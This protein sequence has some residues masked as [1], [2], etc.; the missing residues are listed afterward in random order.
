MTGSSEGRS[1]LEPVDN[2]LA[3]QQGLRVLYSGLRMGACHQRRR[4]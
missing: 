4:E 3:R 2:W 1:A